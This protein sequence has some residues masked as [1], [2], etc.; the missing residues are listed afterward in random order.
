MKTIF[1]Y[2]LILYL[3]SSCN[4][5]PNIY[6]NNINIF[7]FHSPITLSYDTIFQM[8]IGFEDVYIVDSLLLYITNQPNKLFQI[9][10]E[11]KN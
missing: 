7:S 10:S 11:N 1:Y 4:K 9:Y 6:S 3:F 2:L 5:S 8:P